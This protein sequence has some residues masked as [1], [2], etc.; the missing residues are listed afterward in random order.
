MGK[1]KLEVTRQLQRIAALPYNLI[2]EEEAKKIRQKY[3][4]PQH[5]AADWFRQYWHKY[6]KSAT[7]LLGAFKGPRLVPGT[8]GWMGVTD[9]ELAAKAV[10]SIT[11]TKVP[12]EREI[13]LLLSRFGLPLRMFQAVLEY[14]LEDDR[15]WLHLSV[16]EPAVRLT[17]SVREGELELMVTIRLTH[18]TTKK[19]WKEIWDEQIEP[20]LK[21][22]RLAYKEEYGIGDPGRKRTTLV[23]F[24][25]QMKRWSE[26][27]RLSEVEG[28]GPTKALVKWEEECSDERGKFDQSTVTHAIKDFEEII[29]PIA[30]KD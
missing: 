1:Q 3:A 29:T 12:L 9:D 15:R 5:G 13:L 22:M 10:D 27:Y 2:F 17:V 4:I 16:L 14:I 19:H 21:Q 18:L 26:W 23:A 28:L 8:V 30:I 25:E 20:E 6:G 11:D 24:A 7:A